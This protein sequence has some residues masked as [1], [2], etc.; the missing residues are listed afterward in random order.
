MSAAAVPAWSN[1]L[2]ALASV[3]YLGK[4]E[5]ERARDPARAQELSCAARRGV[6]KRLWHRG[7]GG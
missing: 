4:R 3:D 1:L 2:V 6:A 7:E 5:N